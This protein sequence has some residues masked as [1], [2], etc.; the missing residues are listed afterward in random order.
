[1]LDTPISQSTKRLKL[2]DDGQIAEIGRRIEQVL[3]PV[4]GTSLVYAECVTGGRF[5]DIDVNREAAGRFGLNIADVHDGVPTAIVGMTI[6]ESI[7]GLERYPINL[8][9]PR[10]TRNSPQQL[11]SL[12]IVPPD[13]AVISLGWVAE[14]KASEGPDV[15]RSEDA[16]L[17]GWVY[18][19]ITGRDLGS[20][21]D[22]ARRVV[23]EQVELPAGYTIAWSGQ[24]EYM[25][26]AQERFVLV[27]PVI[28]AIIIVLFF[29]HFR[30]VTDVF[31]IMGTLPFGLVDGIWLMWILDCNRSFVVAVGFIALAGVVVEIRVLMVMYLRQEL[32]VAEKEAE[33]DGRG[34]T[35][36]ELRAAIGKG[37]LR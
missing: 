8:R 36:D 4:S 11:R 12:P 34:M 23:D 25:R 32:A 6:G 21:V 7:E 24:Y 1:V 20:Y 19:D 22:E 29:L 5:V 27:G 30:D 28:V 18:V 3:H 26:R 13:G 14:V 16:R 9:Y 15:I 35:V 37:A 17:N 33:K 10:D 31:I 2:S